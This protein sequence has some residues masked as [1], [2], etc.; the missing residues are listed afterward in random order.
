MKMAPAES[1][2]ICSIY[3]K[4]QYSLPTSWPVGRCGKAPFLTKS[5]M[6][7][8]LGCNFQQVQLKTLNGMHPMVNYINIE[9]AWPLQKGCNVLMQHVRLILLPTSAN[10][11]LAAIGKLAIC[12]GVHIICT[13]QG[14]IAGS[15]LYIESRDANR[16]MNRSPN[17]TD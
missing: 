14:R 4:N 13:L 6:R 11:G 12:Y 8:S 2:D 3:I 15:M 17:Y 1:R 7:H 5:T 9:A 10:V 16:S